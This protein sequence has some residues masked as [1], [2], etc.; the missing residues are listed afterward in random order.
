MRASRGLVAGL[1]FV[2]ALAPARAS[3]QATQTPTFPASVE[4]VYVDAVVMEGSRPIADLT[5]LDFELRDEGVVRPVELVA[6]ESLPLLG[7][8]VFDTSGS[9][10]GDKLVA[11]RSA[12]EDFLGIFG[13]ADTVGLLS[14][15]DEIGWAARPTRDRSEVR[16][17]LAGLRARGATSALDALYTALVLPSTPGRSLVV[18]FSDGEDNLS[19]L[20]EAQVRRVVERSNAL[21]HVVGMTPPASD[22]SR[23]MPRPGEAASVRIFREIAEL[24]GGRYWPADSPARLREAFAALA[25]VLQARCVLRFEPAPGRREGWHRIE[26]RLRERS[27]QVQARKGYWVGK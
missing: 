14:F 4:A 22:P 17:A 9:V 8:L 2:G 7:L 3:D 13:P 1:V 10:A 27:G 6:R 16:E 5:A 20:G 18:V 11:L 21:V 24:T 23:R 15:S 26:L 19:W 12:A 25:K